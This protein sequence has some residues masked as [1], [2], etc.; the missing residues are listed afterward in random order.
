LSFE[1]YSVFL[2]TSFELQKS[3]RYILL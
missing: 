2:E 3:V 1:I